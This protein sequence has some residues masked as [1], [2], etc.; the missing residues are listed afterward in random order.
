MLAEENKTVVRRWLEECYNK[1][2]VAAADELIAPDY[3][4][5]SAP[6]GQ[7]PGLDLGWPISDG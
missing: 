4:N 7:M 1:G 5:H 3:I 6:H 2:N